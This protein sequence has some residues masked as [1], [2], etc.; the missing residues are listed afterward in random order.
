[1]ND[2]NDLLSAGDALRLSLSHYGINLEENKFRESLKNVFIQ[3]WKNLQEEYKQTIKRLNEL[4]GLQEAASGNAAKEAEFRVEEKQ[5]LNDFPIGKYLIVEGKNLDYEREMARTFRDLNLDSLRSETRNLEFFSMNQETYKKIQGTINPE[6]KAWTLFVPGGTHRFMHGVV[7]TDAVKVVVVDPTFDLNFQMERI[8]ALGGK[9]NS[10][11]EWQEEEAVLSIK[12]REKPLE[13]RRDELLRYIKEM[14]GIEP[15]VE[16]DKIRFKRKKLIL[17][18]EYEGKT[19]Q[20]IQYGWDAFD[21][22]FWPKELEEGYDAYLELWLRFSMATGGSENWESFNVKALSHLNPAGFVLMD[23]SHDTMMGPQM[24]RLMDKKERKPFV[25]TALG[26]QRIPSPFTEE[27]FAEGSDPVYIVQKPSDFEK[28][29]NSTAHQAVMAIFHELR[30]LIWFKDIEGYI[31][32]TEFIEEADGIKIVQK[33]IDDRKESVLESFMNIRDQISKLTSEEQVQWV[34]AW[35]KDYV[36]ASVSPFK[37]VYVQDE[38]KTREF[39]EISLLYDT[40]IPEKARDLA[41]VRA[42]NQVIMDMYQEA[43]Q[44]VLAGRSE[45][46]MVDAKTR[47][48]LQEW[49]ASMSHDEFARLIARPL[50]SRRIN[51]ILSKAGFSVTSGE[52][53]EEDERK[54]ENVLNLIFVEE[55]LRL[56]DR[57]AQYGEFQLER[58]VTP[59][60]T[61][62]LL[63]DKIFLYELPLLRQRLWKIF[64]Q[65][66]NQSDRTIRRSLYDLL[67]KIGEINPQ[68]ADLPKGSFHIGNNLRLIWGK[69]KDQKETGLP[70]GIEFVLDGSKKAL[71]AVNLVSVGNFSNLKGYYSIDAVDVSEK[72]GELIRE[73]DLGYKIA[74]PKRPLS[75]QEI[76]NIR[77]LMLREIDML[78]YLPPAGASDEHSNFNEVS[79]EKIQSR[80]DEMDEAFKDIY[81]PETGELRSE[82]RRQAASAAVPAAKMEEMAQQFA[83]ILGP[84]EVVKKLTDM[85]RANPEELVD[86][87]VQIEVDTQQFGE[88]LKNQAQALMEKIQSEKTISDGKGGMLT[89]ETIRERFNYWQSLLGQYAGKKFTII[90]RL[91]LD[92]S[93]AQAQ[94]K[95][96]ALLQLKG[97]LERVLLSLQSGNVNDNFSRPLRE[98]ELPFNMIRSL[99]AV[100]GSS[101]TA[102]VVLPVIA[103]NNDFSPAAGNSLFVSVGFN[104][105][106]TFEDD[107]LL[108]KV[109]DFLGPVAGLLL[110][111]EIKDPNELL[112]ETRRSELRAELIKQLFGGDF[113]GEFLFTKDG[114]VFPRSELRRYLMDYQAR[115]TTGA[116]A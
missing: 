80:L 112:S 54:D 33:Y 43:F 11:P 63:N 111:A 67:E 21:P 44:K 82:A 6:H 13:Q 94:N 59:D 103:S 7:L 96:E 52:R 68:W 62:L 19:R 98:G 87:F 57:S 51:Q 27:V 116:A 110:A 84:E 60:T 88:I 89:L 9:V 73:I 4:A 95:A 39:R 70:E 53:L 45:S 79:A 83:L 35:I 97:Q 71:Y 25:E 49:L 109:E 14:G 32:P 3:A 40:N 15:V 92:Y 101:L 17:N 104:I 34:M 65:R 115:K 10:P 93:P 64:N 47:I 46:R 20:L 2:Q 100:R 1:M 76:V 108:E 114:V 12:E 85:P 106:K 24:M 42:L 90:L 29:K 86:Q 16:G 30:D 23:S 18:F 105:D 41:I 61:A 8:T 81:D 78:K 72:A 38:K 75:P 37:Q 74:G 113:S 58:S 31:S 55:T 69:W 91:P 77:K 66:P 50:D 56:L 102:Q 5:F 36:D 28:D 22:E 99:K 48:R 26:Y 107:I